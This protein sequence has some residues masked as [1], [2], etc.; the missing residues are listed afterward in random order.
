MADNRTKVDPRFLKY[1]TPEVE[2]L[3]DK[4]SAQQVAD[5]A[6]IRAMVT[7][8]ETAEEGE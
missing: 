1:D 8:Y 3:L 6:D 4:V 5:E 2:A 7:D